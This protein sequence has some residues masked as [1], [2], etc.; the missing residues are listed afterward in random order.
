[1]P[2]WQK[3]SHTADEKTYLYRFDDRPMITSLGFYRNE[4]EDF[5]NQL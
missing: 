1:V 5:Y 3:Y 2:S 4:T